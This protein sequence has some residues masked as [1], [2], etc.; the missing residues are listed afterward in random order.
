MTRLNGAV[1]RE[2]AESLGAGAV[3][4]LVFVIMPNLGGVLLNALMLIAIIVTVEFTVANLLLFRTFPVA[5]FEPGRAAPMQAAALSFL[6]FLASW[7]VMLAVFRMVHRK[8][9]A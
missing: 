4:T 7:L 9:A 8:A 2:A 3:R 1:L 6:V 5:I